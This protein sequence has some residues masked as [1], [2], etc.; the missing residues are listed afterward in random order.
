[1]AFGG[2]YSNEDPSLLFQVETLKS[3]PGFQYMHNMCNLAIILKVLMSGILINK[4][5]VM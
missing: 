5:T 1:M 4:N 3:G 2:P